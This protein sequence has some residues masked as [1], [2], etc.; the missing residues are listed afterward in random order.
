MATTDVMTTVT[1]SNAIHNG[2]CVVFVSKVDGTKKTL[3]PLLNQQTSPS[4][5]NLKYK[6]R[7]DNYH[8]Y[9]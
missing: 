2:Y 1:N 7:F 8:Y 3:P 6:D 4:G 5:F 9:M